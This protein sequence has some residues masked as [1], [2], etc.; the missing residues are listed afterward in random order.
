M[1]VGKKSHRKK[2]HGKKTKKKKPLKKS[3]GNIIHGK[4]KP[5]KKSQ[6]KINKYIGIK[7]KSIDFKIICNSY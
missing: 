3:H 2:I 7:N 1:N 4:N 5:Q 6:I